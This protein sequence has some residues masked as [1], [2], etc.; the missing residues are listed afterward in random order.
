MC[1]AVTSDGGNITST[2][3]LTIPF[4]IVSPQVMPPIYTL[5][6]CG[7][8]VLNHTKFTAGEISDE[9]YYFLLEYDAV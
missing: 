3:T 5:E 2:D 7:I 1:W 4:K 9:C 8:R 6:I